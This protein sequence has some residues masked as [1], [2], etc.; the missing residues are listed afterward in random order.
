MTMII[1]LH[2]HIWTSLDQLGAEMANRIRE[3]QRATSHSFEAS[4][5][6]HDRAM[7]CVDGSVV[8]GFRSD[9]LQAN[10][11]NELIADF[12][13]KAPQ[14]RVGIAGIDPLADDASDQL[15]NAIDLGLVG[16]SV[17][18]AC[19]GFHPA[20]SSAMR[21]YERCQELSLS[22]FVAMLQ[23]LTPSAMLEF[24]RPML[25]DEVA[26][27][28]PNLPIILSQLGYPWVEEA[29]LLLS[30]HDNMFA[31]TS[32]LSQQPLQLYN[33]LLDAMS[34][35]VIPKLVFG[36]GFPYD[37]P[38]KAIETLYRINSQTQG[39]QL[40]AIPRSQLRAIVE[41]D[42]LSCLGI[43]S[44]IHTRSTSLEQTAPEVVVVDQS[45]KDVPAVTASDE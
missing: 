19:Q 2:T 24:G 22:I 16:I 23:P 26:R 25:W 45:S 6:A 21:I 29:L 39:T 36:S 12:V 38:A 31:D 8:W 14:H 5:A 28:F 27:T 17:S 4:I 20:H 13:A 1:D 34:L 18:P 9:L 35:G 30:K 41:R 15:D 33:A 3:R 37:T 42:S 40:P 10:V 11:P 44:I 7:T 32:G 43:E